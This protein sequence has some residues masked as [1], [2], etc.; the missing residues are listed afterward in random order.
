ME[1][2]FIGT[3]S[4]RTSL[5][6]NHSSFCFVDSGKTV[7]MDAGDGISNALL[8][9]KIEFNSIADIIISHYHSDH[10][11]GLPSLLTQM[12][13]DKRTNKLKI[14]THD[15]L[16]NSLVTFLNTSYIFLEKLNFV[17]QIV[18]FE[19]EESINLSNKM[20]FSA[21]KNSHIRNKHNLSIDNINFISSSFLFKLGKLKIVYTSDI[22]SYEDLFL[23]QESPIN[24]FITEAAHI[25]L[26]KIENA[27][28]ILNPTQVYL[29][30]ID[31]EEEI[32]NW[33]RELS[34]EKKQTIIVAK[35]GM[36][37]I[38]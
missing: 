8:S 38:L 12:I 34:I 19:F 7:L 17:V 16:V 3:G 27:I 2:L 23:F 35:D 14:F 36:K 37:I 31:N 5:N 11:A 18:P 24:I 29:T 4:G 25:P 26:E 15:H 28:T 21:K 9:Q 22:G 20:T 6:R 10:L 33:F 13:I 30:H 1:L 32:H